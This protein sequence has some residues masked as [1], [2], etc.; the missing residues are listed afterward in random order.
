VFIGGAESFIAD[1]FLWTRGSLAE[2]GAVA[3]PSLSSDVDDSSN[4]YYGLVRH[5]N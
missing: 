3:G 1:T 4:K 5:D 2:G